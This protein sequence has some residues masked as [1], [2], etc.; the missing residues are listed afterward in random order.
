[1]S[2]LQESGP[3]SQDVFDI[4]F[5]DDDYENFLNDI[6]VVPT[7]IRGNIIPY[8]D[9][10]LNTNSSS[11]SLNESIKEAALDVDKRSINF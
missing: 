9:Y 8:N 5:F 10:L 1:M 2:S 11:T 4:N 6:I 3:N 7:E